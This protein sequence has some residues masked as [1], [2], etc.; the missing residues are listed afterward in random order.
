[1]PRIK[2]PRSQEQPAA[3]LIED[4]APPTED[5]EI[6]LAPDDEPV[7]IELAP[8]PVEPQPRSTPAPTDDDALVRAAEATRRAEDL[9]RRNAELE[10]QNRDRDEELARERGRGDEAEYNSVLTAIAAEQG[11]LSKAKSD[12]TTAAAAS[13]WAAA[14]EA[15]EAIAAARGRL[16]RLEDGKQAFESRRETRGT[17]PRPAAPQTLDFEQKITAL[18]DTAKQWLRKHPE[19]I[20]DEALNRKIG[21]T[22]NYLVDNKGVAAFTPAYFDALD[23][24]FGFKGASDPDPQPQPQAQPQAQLQRRSIPMSAPVSRDVPTASGQRQSDNKMTLTPKEREIARLSIPDTPGLPK[25][26]N[27]EKELMY[28][29]NKARLNT[30]KANGTY[31]ERRE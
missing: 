9:Q 12:Y 5:I 16:D 21:A 10:R 24:E 27:A 8:A 13:D 25:L 3:D 18:P 14:G 7:E 6:V 31:S 1:M 15:Q 23:A 17:E 26:S 2:P 11:A 20:N 19:F 22:H 30:M 4:N 29:K 28:A